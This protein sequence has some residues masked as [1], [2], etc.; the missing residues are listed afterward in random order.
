M[1]L[2]Q[3]SWGCCQLPDTL[4][5]VLLHRTVLGCSDIPSPGT[6]QQGASA[7][8]TESSVPDARVKMCPRRGYRISSGT[9]VL[10]HICRMCCLG[11]WGGGG[12]CHSLASPER[13]RGICMGGLPGA[14]SGQRL[15]GARGA[16]GLRGSH[17]RGLWTPCVLQSW[18]G[19]AELR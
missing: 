7:H 15:L 4:N 9:A 17:S 2:G 10:I 5:P 3:P 6:G 19:P 8:P 13:L 16:A 18:G 1:D 11:P 12:T 14:L